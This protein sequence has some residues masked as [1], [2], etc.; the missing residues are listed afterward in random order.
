M[1]R[2]GQYRLYNVALDSGDVKQGPVV[3]RGSVGRRGFARRSTGWQQV[4]KQRAA[5][6]LSNGM[7]Y[8]AFGGDTPPN[9]GLA[10]WLFVYDAGTLA[11]K[12]VWSPTPNGNN[13]GIWQ[14]GQGPAADNA[15]N[16]YLQT[17]D[18]DFNVQQ[19]SYG[20]S[21][22]RLRLDPHGIS[23]DDYFSPCNQ[24]WMRFDMRSRS[25]LI[26]TAAV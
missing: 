16:V 6:L 15:G 13:A 7:L 21:I 14:A 5:L 3:V 20:D 26:R 23:V 18:G 4:R 11:L 19:K 2:D 9:S 12:T 8:V 24:S 22:V 10:G 1:E 17:G 25:R